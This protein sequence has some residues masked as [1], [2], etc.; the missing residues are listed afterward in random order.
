MFWDQRTLELTLVLGILTSKNDFCYKSH[1][2][3]M[4]LVSPHNLGK[5]PSVY[6]NIEPS[7]S[8]AGEGMPTASGCPYFMS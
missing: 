8:G 2:N 5:K 3:S 1:T 7:E 6:I 4:L